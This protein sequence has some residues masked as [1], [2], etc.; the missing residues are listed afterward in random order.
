[1]ANSLEGMA[2]HDFNDPDFRR[3]IELT[4]QTYSGQEIADANYLAWEYHRNPDGQSIIFVAE[5]QGKI[6]SQYLVLP[7]TYKIRD[8]KVKVHCP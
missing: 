7:R 3:L 5:D 8:E 6:V 4:N 2:M 1:M